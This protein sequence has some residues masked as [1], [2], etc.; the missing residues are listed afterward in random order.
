MPRFVLVALALVSLAGCGESS[1]GG[2]AGGAAASHPEG[3]HSGDEESDEDA[4]I[5]LGGATLPPLPRGVSLE[6]GELAA[7]LASGRRMLELA[8]PEA[9]AEL[10]P[11]DMQ[12]WVQGA[13]A[14]WMRE[15]GA[16]LREASGHLSLG[17]E[18][19]LGDYV[20]GSALLGTLLARFA[21]DL[22]TMPLPRA[23][24]DD[25]SARIRYRDAF[26]RAAQPLWERAA[27]AFGACASASIRARDGRIRRWGEHCDEQVERVEAAPRPLPE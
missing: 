20:V 4:T 12:A 16:A 11:E 2:G 10:A 15:R 9:G 25:A 24:Q 17:D 21:E 5:E 23:V 27:D 22:G 18:A 3:D 8:R 19:E 13:F 1:S 14:V 6:E 26:L 7:G